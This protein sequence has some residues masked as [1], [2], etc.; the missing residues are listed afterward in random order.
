MFA[1]LNLFRLSQSSTMA[2]RIDALYDFVFWISV[3]CFAGIVGGLVFFVFRYHRTRKDPGKTPYITGHT[4]LELGVSGVLFV[5]VMIIFYWGWEDYKKIIT[6]VSNAVEINVVGRQWL[7][8]FEYSNGRKMTNEAVVPKETPVRLIL[9]SADVL[10]SFYVPD[11]RLKQDVVPGAYNSLN[12]TATAAG[13][14]Q[15]YCAEFCGTAH[16]KMLAT[17]KVVEP[18]DYE[19]WQAEWE[20]S[21]RLGETS[22]SADSDAAVGDMPSKGGKI[23]AER[24]CT[25]CHTVTGVL[26][27]GPSLKGV[28]GHEVTLSDGS[29]VKADENYLRKSLMEPVAQ[30]VKGFQPVMPTYQ[31]TLSDEEINALVAYIKSLL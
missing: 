12:F 1:L 5:L 30:V 19:R 8:E 22:A 3:I 27:V 7:W 6:P 14:Y 24:G 18:K 23:F 2:P 11:F 21:Q 16:S 29:T 9:A 26:L 4:K 10:H 13:D 25:A 20:L 28:F 31:G 17:L 15:V